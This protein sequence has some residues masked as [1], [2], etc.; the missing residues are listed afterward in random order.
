MSRRPQ[1]PKRVRSIRERKFGKRR[2]G[3]PNW[4]AVIVVAAAVVVVGLIVALFL[5][6]RHRRAEA[7]PAPTSA[8]VEP[9]A[10]AVPPATA[11]PEPPPP[12]STPQPTVTVTPVPQPCQALEPAWVRAQPADQSTG[13]V[14]LAPGDDVGVIG[15]VQNEAGETWLQVVGYAGPAYVR[16][17]KVQCPAP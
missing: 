14:Q 17:E 3:G 9:L 13:L 12:T 16:A 15:Q 6:Y 7:T 5:T 1:K 10:S 2:A 4:P 8:T 11:T